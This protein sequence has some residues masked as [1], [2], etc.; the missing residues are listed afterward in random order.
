MRKLAGKR[1]RQEGR[2]WID[3]L[4][5][6]D[7][8]GEADSPQIRAL[9][10]FDDNTPDDEVLFL[11]RLWARHFFWRFFSAKDAE[12]HRDSDRMTL[13]VWRGKEKV[14]VDIAF[15]GAAK[16]TRKKLFVAFAIANDRSRRRR[17]IK[18]L[19]ADSGNAVQ[20][21]TDVYN[22]LVNPRVRRHYPEIFRKTHEKRAERMSE[23][24]TATGI[25][26]SAGSVQ[27][28]QRGDVQE[29]ARP[30]FIIFD[31]FENRKILRSA[32]TLQQVWENMEEAVTGL[33]HDGGA[34]YCGNYI[35]E[36]GNVHRIIH[37]F[38]KRTMMTPIKGKVVGGQFHDGPSNWPEMFPDSEI[39]AIL[40]R[41]DDPNGEYLCVPSAG[42]DVFFDREMVNRQE[43]RDPLKDVGGMKIFFEYDPAHRYGLG[44]DVGGGIGLDSSTAAIIDFSTIPF[45][46]V[47]TFASNRVKPDAFGDEIA[48]MAQMYGDPIVAPENNRYDMCI[49]RLK[50]LGVNL[51]TSSGPLRKIGAMQPRSYGWNT[52]A[53]T[54]PKM[55]YDLKRAIEDGLLEVSDIR[56]IEE[57]RAFSRDD[58]MDAAPDP[59]LTT[60]HFDLLTAVAIAYQM[61][62][63]AEHLMTR[64]ETLEY[65][66][67]IRDDA[68]DMTADY[69]L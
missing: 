41:A 10:G 68:Q 32:V 11:F 13:E 40:S 62:Y 8:E 24:V 6:A 18:F 16:T 59:R 7:I 2:R 26:V 38:P 25:K 1:K 60:R 21:V 57:L 63:H 43:A 34:I 58:L 45:R 23:F 31:D 9:F 14:F 4:L 65:R 51:Y 55:L 66:R 22:I 44:A 17:F 52:N 67:E 54:K 15:R 69:G 53:A 61:K 33:S 20:N 35:S 28:A 12:F 39:P 47:L 3:R 42:D 56:V 36:R 5:D 19:S 46:V 27:T 29:E 64:E 30:D 49:G 50:Q 37:R 48:R